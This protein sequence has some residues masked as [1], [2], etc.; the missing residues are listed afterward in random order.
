MSC[1]HQLRGRQVARYFSQEWADNG[2]VTRNM[3]AVIFLMERNL[4]S[5]RAICGAS[6]T[7][8]AASKSS[9][10]TLRS[11]VLS[12]QRSQGIPLG[13]STLSTPE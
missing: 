2:A 13:P 6:A 1:R 9:R 10:P 4:E 8:T 12:S 11:L 3:K 5:H 7:A